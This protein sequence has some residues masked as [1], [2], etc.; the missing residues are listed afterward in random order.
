MI[1]H[2]D[3]DCFFVSA[4]RTRNAALRGVPTV[5]ANRNDTAIFGADKLG[6]SKTAHE[7]CGV[8]SGACYY[9]KFGGSW[10]SH[11]QENGRIRGMVVAASYEAR[12]YEIKTGLAL[13]EALKLC[14]KLKILPT[15]MPF[16]MSLSHSLAE[17][18]ESRIPKLEQFS[19]DEFFGEL[20]GFVKPDETEKYIR[21]L[22]AAIYEEFSLPVTIGA[23]TNK[24]IAKLA[25]KSAKPFGVRVVKAEEIAQFIDD[26]P[27]KMVAG[28]GRQTALRLKRYGAST[29]GDLVRSPTLLQSLGKNGQM[30][31]EELRG[32]AHSVVM[33]N[34]ER[35]QIGI[36]R[37]FDPLIDRKELLRRAVI[38]CGHLSYNILR[39]KKEPTSF[40]FVIG[41]DR[42]GY[43]HAKVN[44]DRVFSEA[45]LVAIARETL[46][47]IDKY[48]TEKVVYMA[49]SA[50]D[51]RSKDHTDELLNWQADRKNRALSNALQIVRSK[52]G[53]SAIRLP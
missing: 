46:K 8:F 51:F 12:S 38:L 29:L 31:L 13:G 2:L 41:Y 34:S 45:L 5:V 27:L 28:I 43:E 23:S 9:N 47:T 50:G 7:A 48:S 6:A 14:P 10:E 39:H 4:E 37:V 42:F 33:H 44:S 25:V 53:Y 40:N 22:Q 15:D 17:Y 49:V 1:M 24:S 26:K 3:L 30:L 52:Y 36:S 32:K 11:F 19:I 35:K 16:Y 18:L 21:H 20:D